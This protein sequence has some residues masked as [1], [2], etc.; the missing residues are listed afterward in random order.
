MGK[1]GRDK[2][3]LVIGIAKLV[4]GLLLLAL[5]VGALSL[6]HKDVATEMTRWIRALNMDPDNRY[7]QRVLSKGLGLDAKKLS[8]LTVGTFFYSALF[9]IEGVGLL[10]RK[11]WAEYF[12][13][14]ITGSFVPIEIYEL[15]KHFSP[16]KLVLLV[17]NVAIVIYLVW[18]LRTERAK[19]SSAARQKRSIK[20]KAVAA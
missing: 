15:A 7:F 9:L 16:F 13:A 4:K 20:A 14:I 6:F 10:L 1:P 17:A 12:T 2:W 8:L 3:L 18:R 11:R 5:A 19:P